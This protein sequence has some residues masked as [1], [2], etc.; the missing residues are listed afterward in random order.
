MSD[1][2]N[3][4]VDPPRLSQAEIDLSPWYE[5]GCCMLADGRLLCLCIHAML[6]V[7]DPPPALASRATR[8]PPLSEDALRLLAESGD[9]RSEGMRERVV[10]ILDAAKIG[11]PDMPVCDRC[12]GTGEARCAC[13]EGRGKYKCADPTC[14]REHACGGCHG[15]CGARCDQCLAIKPNDRRVR[16]VAVVTIQ[17]HRADAFYLLPLRAMGHCSFRIAPHNSGYA[18]IFDDGQRTL[19]VMTRPGGDIKDVEIGSIA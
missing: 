19:V 14:K 4:T 16:P 2:A 17:G 6:A 9:D 13:C 7:S 11:L 3:H 5:P 8:L 18:M 1:T 10:A 15:L 12:G